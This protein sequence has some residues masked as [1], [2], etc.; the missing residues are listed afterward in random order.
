MR[1]F[2][3]I[4]LPAETRAILERACAG[5]EGARW[6]RPENMHLTLRFIGEVGGTE[7]GDI[8]A[9]LGDVRAAGFELALNGLGHFGNGRKVR[10]LWAAV[11][12]GQ[13]LARLHEKVEAAVVRAG[14]EP[15]GRKFRP[16]VT[17]AR[18]KGRPPRN[19]GDYLEAHNRL[20]TPAFPVV[21][22]TLFESHMGHGGSHY[23]ALSDYALEASA[24]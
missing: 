16:H 22:F 5:L 9:A 24:E 10:A 6:V 8:D 7:A 21:A 14:R 23:E 2:V 13:P 12:A 4:R 15:E 3:G 11:E 20:S 19:L 18:F 17:L 1:L